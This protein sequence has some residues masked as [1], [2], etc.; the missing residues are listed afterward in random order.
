MFQASNSR[1]EPVSG[2][3]DAHS[4]SGGTL[5]SLES[6]PLLELPG[7]GVEVVRYHQPFFFL[8]GLSFEQESAWL[9]ETPEK[10]GAC[11]LYVASTQHSK[12]PLS[13]LTDY[14]GSDGP[15]LPKREIRVMHNSRK[16]GMSLPRAPSVPLHR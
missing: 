15:L 13:V 2:A 1:Q 14:Q 7:L 3:W 12:G 4:G 9:R 16:E 5:G 6:A 8:K 11:A 10:G